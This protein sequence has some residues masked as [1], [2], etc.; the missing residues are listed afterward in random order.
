MDINA[1]MVK[2][3]VVTGEFI[4][5]LNDLNIGVFIST[6]VKSNCTH[7]L[8]VRPKLFTNLT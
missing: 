6:P 7:K 5:K 3:L 2:I 8:S 1:D 4:E